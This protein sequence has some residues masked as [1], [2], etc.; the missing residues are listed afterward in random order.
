MS[1]CEPRRRSE[2]TCGCRCWVLAAWAG[3]LAARLLPWPPGAGADRWSPCSAW[4]C[5]AVGLAGR[6]LTVAGV[7]LVFAGVLL[8][9][10]LRQEQVSANPVASLARERA[11]AVVDLR[12]VSDPR[13]VAGRYGDRVLVRG[14]VVRSHRARARP[15]DSWR[16]CWCSP[17][18]SGSRP[19]WAARC[20]RPA[21]L[22][23]ADE[24]GARGR[25]V[26]AR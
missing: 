2:P 16:R 14:H 9:G 24:P 13:V 22:S 26:G 10:V 6:L 21:L 5:S 25:G 18:A 15:I 11:V 1:R 4:S 8:A 17:I 3:G 19:G 20:A 7:L 12:V 23:P